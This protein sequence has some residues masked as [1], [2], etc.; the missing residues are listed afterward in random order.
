MGQL[1]RVSWRTAGY[2]ALATALVAGSVIAVLNSNGVKPTALTSNSATK[3]LVDR[4]HGNVVLVDGLAGNVLAKIT[5]DTSLR[6]EEAVQGAGGAFLVGRLQ[7]SIRTIS[8]SKLQLGTAQALALLTDPKSEFGVG[9][10]GLTVVS[11]DSDKAKVVA[12]DDVSRDV[13][14]PTSDEA[15]VAGDGSMW[16]LSQASATHVNVDQ[17]SAT[18]P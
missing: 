18:V 2:A 4:V 7:G 9:A 6:D 17:S 15:L 16:L 8:T 14:V 10:S 1:Q 13:D 5:T 11:P 3:W 12:V